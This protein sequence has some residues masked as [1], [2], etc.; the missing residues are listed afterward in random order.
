MIRL[1]YFGFS[2][3]FALAATSIAS[4]QVSGGEITG[5]ISDPTGAIAAGATV[6]LTNPATNSRRVVKTSASGAYNLP[7][8][9]PGVYNLRV[10]MPRFATESRSGVELQIGQVARIDFT[11]KV[12]SVSEVV[13]VA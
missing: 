6:T 12:G 11:L 10:E 3:L 8:L 5:T 9:E 7:A 1:R 2:I 4:A 13:E